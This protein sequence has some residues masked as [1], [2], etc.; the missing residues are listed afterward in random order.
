MS[1]A[2]T[3]KQ[4]VA[5]KKETTEGVQ[6][7]GFAG[8]DYIEVSGDLGQ[9]ELSR[10]KIERNIMTGSLLPRKSKMGPRSA[11]WSLGV[12]FT[13]ALVA[14]QAPKHTLLLEAAG[15]KKVSVAEKTIGSGSTTTVIALSN[16][17]SMAVGHL[18]KILNAGKHEIRRIVSLVTNTSITLDSALSAAPDS[19][20]KVAASVQFVFDET[21]ESSVTALHEVAEQVQQYLLGCKVN[22]LAY[23]NGTTGQIGI[24]TYG[25][26]ALDYVQESGSSLGL[27][28]SYDNAEPA[29][30]LGAQ[31]R[32]N[33][34]SACL[35][36]IGFS[37]EP[38]LSAKSCMRMK[39]GKETQRKSSLVGTVNFNPY[40]PD[41][42]IPYKLDESSLDVIFHVG[43]PTS[44]DGETEHDY[45]ISFPKVMA[46]QIVVADN[47]GT[48]VDQVTAEIFEEAPV[49]AFF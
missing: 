38:A 36:E 48:L 29:P 16:T 28:P 46:T 4:K 17:S 42:S 44:T 21:E 49:I 33:G 6:A 24:M 20:D 3:N 18:V 25:L 39:N 1:D 13:S 22:N 2:L 45:A 26:S 40:K 43:L 41:N 9:P 32:I 7:T 23:S 27:T 19:G 12:E 5:I 31:V 37:L 35:S 14:G 10:E 8:S 34:V 11:S 30:L 47:E 15:F